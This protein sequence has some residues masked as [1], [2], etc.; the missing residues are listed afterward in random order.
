MKFLA[1]ACAA[2]IMAIG[3]LPSA[4]SLAAGIPFQT[5]V[6][7]DEPVLYYQF[8]Q[9]SGDVTNHGT[10]GDA[11]NGAVN[12]TP[13]R[14]VSS[15]AGDTA[16]E[17]DA[18]D[19]YIESLNTV[20]VELT[21][22]PSF[23]A[24]AVYF[25]P[26]GGTARL[27]APLL[28]WGSSGTGNSVYFS[29]SNHDSDEI[30]AGFYNGGLQTPVGFVPL[31]EWHHVVWVHEGSGTDQEGTTLYIDGVDVSSLLI[32]D[33][34]LCCNGSTPTVTAAEFRVN[35]AR[36]GT[37]FFTGKIDEL[38]LYDKLLTSEQVLAHWELIRN[39][40]FKDS[41]ETP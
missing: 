4:D 14:D 9:D 36:D 2:L 3:I 19:D 21:G 16:I 38:A 40:I 17:F 29:F 27:W 24:E 13:T 15:S 32:P 11:Y 30:Y 23:T 31:G 25:I 20:P 22:H 41:F 39:D 1:P 37:R 10:W 6:L 34:A 12:G 8:N 28:H 7:G 33:P 5:T 35:R 26:I 18:A